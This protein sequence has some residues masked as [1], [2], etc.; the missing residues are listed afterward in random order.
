[1]KFQHC[2]YPGKSLRLNCGEPA[3]SFV[4]CTN[5]GYKCH[6]SRAHGD[7][8]DS[9]PVSHFEF[10]PAANVVVGPSVSQLVNVDLPVTINTHSPGVPES[11][12]QCL[13]G[14]VEELVNDIHANAKEAVVECLSSDA[15]K[16]TMKKI[17]DCFDQLENPFSCINTESKRTKHFEEKWKIVEPVEYTLGVR[18][19]MCRDKTMTPVNDKFMY[20][21]IIGSLSSMFRNSA[22]CNS[23]QKAKPHQDGFYSE[24]TDGSYFKNHNLISQQEH[25]LQIQLC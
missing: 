7:S 3:C 21:P 16:E 19:D 25:A 14:S 15:S 20:V 12:V 6:L 10:E 24:I 17:E 13:V 18:F 5:S 9:H 4:F 23:F 11:T 1:M 2:L 22:L 8:I